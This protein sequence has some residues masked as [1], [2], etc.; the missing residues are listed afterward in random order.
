MSRTVHA[1]I[2]LD[3]ESGFHLAKDDFSIARILGDHFSL[4]IADWETCDELSD[5]LRIASARIQ[6]AQAEKEEG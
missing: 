2:M 1:S 4:C 5:M 6:K 3:K